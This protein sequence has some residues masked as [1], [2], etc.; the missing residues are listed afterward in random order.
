MEPWQYGV[1]GFVCAL[2]WQVVFW[3]TRRACP[4]MMTPVGVAFRNY[5]RRRRAKQSGRPA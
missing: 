1:T 4:C 3:I 2:G 5:L